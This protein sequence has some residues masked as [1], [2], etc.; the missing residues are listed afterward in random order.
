MSDKPTLTEIADGA[1]KIVIARTPQL[2]RLDLAC[3][4][5]PAPGYE[6]VDFYAP[7]AKH[8]WDLQTYPWPIPDNSVE[9]L[10]CSHYIEHIPMEYLKDGPHKGKDALFAFFDE[11]YRVMV[12]GADLHIACPCARN[13]RAFQDPTH[14]R[15]IV[16]ETFLYM[17]DEWRKMNKLDHY[18]A[19]CNFGVS[20]NPVVS[21]DLAKTRVQEWQNMAFN[22][23]WNVVLDWDAHCKSLKVLKT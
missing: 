5:S 13:N 15:F 6:G 1:N 18:N 21:A 4:Q 23:Y 9:A 2:L 11:C 8:K 19:K 10:R 12:P 14:R 17:N 22:S 16:A 7:D 20:C 3:G